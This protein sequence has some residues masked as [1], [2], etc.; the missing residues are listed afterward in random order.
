MRSCGFHCIHGQR[1]HP[2]AGHAAADHKQPATQSH[3]GFSA[4]GTQRRQPRRRYG[5]TSIMST[6]LTLLGTAGGPTPKT[7]RSSPAQVISVDGDAYVIDCGNCVAKQYVKAGFSF[8]QLRSVFL[9]HHHSDH[10]ADYG[11]LLLL[12]WGANLSHAVT[13][14]GPPPI[15]AMT[16][17]FLKLNRVDIRSEEH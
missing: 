14:H 3:P 17:D 13:T 7:R 11:N 15:A 10:N 6:T 16:R 1:N 5:N 12:G 2:G 4:A 9:T 8:K